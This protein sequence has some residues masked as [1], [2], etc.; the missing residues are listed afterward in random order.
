MSHGLFLPPSLDI[1][2]PYSGSTLS[3]WPI[4][5]PNAQFFRFQYHPARFVR[6]LDPV[7]DRVAH[8]M[9]PSIS[10]SDVSGR[11]A[12]RTQHDNYACRW[13]HRS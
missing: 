11:R 2:K 10:C 6:P 12:I 9:L 4:H 8:Q 5:Y 13:R 3:F 1:V 7:H